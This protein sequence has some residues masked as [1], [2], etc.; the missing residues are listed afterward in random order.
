MRTRRIL[1]AG[2]LLL[3]LGASAHV[4]IIWHLASAYPP[5]SFHGENLAR[6]ANDV[7]SRSGGRLR[8]IVHANA[9]EHKSAEIKGDVHSGRSQA[10]EILLTQ[11]ADEA[12][13]YALD[14]LPFLA[15]GY[16]EACKLYRAQKHVLQARLADQG[17]QLLY[18]V[19]WPPQ[20]IFANKAIDSISD[21]KGLRFRAYSPVTSRIARLA[22]AEPVTMQ[23]AELAQILAVAAGA[24]DGQ[25]VL[26]TGIIDAF[27]SSAATGFDAKAYQYFTKFYH[28]QAW[29]PKNAVI[30]NQ[31][32]LGALSSGTR[33]AV[34]EAAA[35]A[36]TRGW[37]LSELTDQCYRQKLRDHGM[38]V[39]QPTLTLDTGLAEIGRRMLAE[40]LQGAGPEGE[41]I[42]D[43]YRREQ[44]TVGSP[45]E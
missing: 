15:R 22:G 1:C 43:A 24:D 23:Q 8:I 12:P 40:W 27:I 37:A 45:S 31:A 35:E 30:V 42:I 34:L 20:G 16:Q 29:L 2:G 3:C 26:A 6:F 36:E 10:G 4:Q 9:Y 38:T 41:A 44:P 11:H 18:A 32:A 25:S 7:Q 13:V 17:M 33:T 19:P 5:D 21:F 28:V 14:G 39:L